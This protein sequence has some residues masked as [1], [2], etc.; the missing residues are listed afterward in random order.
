MRLGLLFEIRPGHA[1]EQPPYDLFAEFETAET[2]QAIVLALEQLGHTVALIDSQKSPLESLLRLKPT[3]DLVV[4][5]SVGFGS[6][7]RELLPAAICEILAIPYTGSDAMSQAIAANKNLAKLV[8][9]AGGVPTPS[10][11]VAGSLDE[12]FGADIH[13]E[14]V[15]I[16]PLFEGS[17]IGVTG[18]ID[19]GTDRGR[20]MEESERLLNIYRQPI[21]VEEF[22]AG[23]EITVPILGNPPRPL[24]P[25]GLSLHGSLSLGDHIFDSSAKQD[26]KAA[27]WHASLPFPPALLERLCSL[28]LKVHKALGCLDL[29][30][31]DFR[32]EVP[33][34]GV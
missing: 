33:S 10:W 3:L 8:A 30:R 32:V 12:V 20:L 4:N 29:S 28:G 16:K 18:P 17:S 15:I 14:R 24:T 34:R 21:L 1:S 26:P 5:C 23:F 27:A 19:I 11:A 7:T 25:V 13:S 31:S 2:I 9:R 22:I 6:R